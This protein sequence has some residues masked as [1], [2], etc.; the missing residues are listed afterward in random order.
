MSVNQVIKS[1]LSS[2]NLPVWYIK[3]PENIKANDYIT[4]NYLE[5]GDWYSNDKAEITKYQ[6]T[7]N[8][9]TNDVDGSIVVVKNIKDVL[10]LNNSC[11]SVK[12]YPTVYDNQKRCYLTVFTFYLYL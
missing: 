11:M 2:V 6:V 10:S 5:I 9:I 3:K 8:Y 7:L 4:F 12:K 1:T